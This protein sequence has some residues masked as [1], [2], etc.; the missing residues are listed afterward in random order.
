[1]MLD[2]FTRIVFKYKIFIVVFI[3]VVTSIVGIVN[4][5]FLPTVYRGVA[6]LSVAQIGSNSNKPEFLLD[7]DSVIAEI[8]SDSFLQIIAENVGLR[9]KQLE[10][11]LRV[12]KEGDSVEITFDYSDKNVIKTIF[13]KILELINNDN[14]GL[15]ESRIEGIKAMMQ[16]VSQQVEVLKNQKEKIFSEINQFD[17]NPSLKAQNYLE[18]SLLNETYNSIAAQQKDLEQQ[19]VLLKASLDNSNVFYYKILPVIL[20]NPVAPRKVF[21]MAVAAVTAFFISLLVVL[22]ME[23]SKRA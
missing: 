12:V 22:M 20:D 21:N 13:E 17:Q 5:F 4:F 8:K 23:L 16:Q 9:Y 1:M 18:Y 11:S 7:P 15:Y 19:L 14:K 2:D 10:D 6:L 3:V